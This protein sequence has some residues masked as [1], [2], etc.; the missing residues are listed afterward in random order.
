MKFLIDKLKLKLLLETRRNYIKNPIEGIDILIA[1]ITYIISLLCSDF[2]DILGIKSDVIQT[3]AW[4]FAVALFIY[5]IYRLINSLQH[6]YDHNQLFHE[7]ENLNEVLHSFSIIAI[8]D[9]FNNF[10]NRYLLY[11]DKAWKCWFFFSF[12]TSESENESFIKQRLSNILKIEKSS[13]SLK[14]ISDRIQPK[15]SERDNIHKVYNH[16]LYEGTLSNFPE[17]IKQDSFTIDNIDYKWFTI[18]EL[19][20]DETVMNKNSDVVNFVKEKIC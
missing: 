3:I 6:K 14:Y 4:I 16:S 5:G 20:S 10:S 7:I 2:K 17:L 8:K 1:A 15:Y 12:K 13:I 11:Y 9:T 18:E 19:E